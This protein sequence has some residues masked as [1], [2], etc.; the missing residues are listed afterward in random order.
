M[1]AAHVNPPRTLS[2]VYGLRPW[3]HD[4][5]RLGLRTNFDDE[6]PPAS[7]RLRNVV[8]EVRRV[9]SRPSG[10]FS[11]RRALGPV[12]SSHRLNQGP[13][14]AVLVPFLSRALAERTAPARCLELF[15]ADG[16]YAC[17]LAQTRPDAVVWGVDRDARQIARARTAARLLGCGNV[18][19][20]DE[21]IWAF[22]R[23]QEQPFDLVL[24]AG[25]LYHLA[26]PRRLLDVLRPLTRGFLVVQSVVTLT[27]E[28]PAYFV[29]PAPGWRHGSRFTH[30]GLGRWLDAL[31]WTIVA[32][33]RNELPGNAR[34]EDRGSSYYL[35]RAGRDGFAAA[36]DHGRAG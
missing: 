36:E 21:D 27:S 11:L 26:E 12:A 16:Y 28:D 29:T 15:C 22:L 19:F 6:P 7:E 20:A 5:A 18:W 25:G 1:T 14:E 9:W 33:D 10:G 30:A 3:Y 35:C 4:F 24:C 31:G 2:E 34:P 23:Q 17:L 13:K 8:R 32:A